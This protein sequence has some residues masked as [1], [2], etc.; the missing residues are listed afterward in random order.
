MLDVTPLWL[1]L[2]QSFSTGGAPKFSC[3]RNLEKWPKFAKNTLIS[4]AF[5]IEMA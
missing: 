2:V 1:F 5:G 3:L 4:K